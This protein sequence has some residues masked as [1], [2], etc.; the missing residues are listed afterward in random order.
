MNYGIHIEKHVLVLNVLVKKNF[1]R[2]S[3]KNFKIIL[4]FGGI[5]ITKK[6]KKT[7]YSQ[8]KNGNMC[9]Q[10]THSMYIV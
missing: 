7:T 6:K 9:I 5:G 3:G 1:D 10:Y 8:T 4:G 2:L